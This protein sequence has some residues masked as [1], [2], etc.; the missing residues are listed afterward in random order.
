[1]GTYRVALAAA[2]NNDRGRGMKKILI[3]AVCAAQLACGQWIYNPPTLRDIKRAGGATTSDFSRILFQYFDNTLTNPVVKIYNYNQSEQL[4]AITVPQLYPGDALYIEGGM[5]SHWINQGYDWVLELVAF[6][7]NFFSVI[8]GYTAG[9]VLGLSLYDA[10]LSGY[11]S[12][13]GLQFDCVGS[14]IVVTAYVGGGG[15]MSA[16]VRQTTTEEEFHPATVIRNP[17]S[18]SLMLWA[19]SGGINADPEWI[20][21]EGFGPTWLKVWIERRHQ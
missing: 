6:E 9:S 21:S 4:P 18:E 11:A 5:P 7:H 14:N 2:R 1:M 10:P 12:M 20:Y 19:F 17:D 8:G 3:M 13:F 15:S 16:V